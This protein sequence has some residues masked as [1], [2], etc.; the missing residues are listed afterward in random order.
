MKRT[1]KS[2]LSSFVVVGVWL[3]FGKPLPAQQAAPSLDEV[4]NQGLKAYESLAQREAAAEDSSF[5]SNVA[6]ALLTYALLRVGRREAVDDLFS[7]EAKK[8]EVVAFTEDALVE[9]TGEVPEIPSGMAPADELV[10]RQTIAMSLARRGDFKKAVEQ[11]AEFPKHA[12]MG[13]FAIHSYQF[14]AERQLERQDLAGAR[15]TVRK[16]WAYIRD[17][18]DNDSYR[19]AEWIIQLARTTSQAGEQKPAQKLCRIAGK[20]L[21]QLRQTQGHEPQPL[22]DAVRELAIAHAMSGNADRA[23]A[24]LADCE[25]QAESIE[26]GRDKAEHMFD[27]QVAHARVAQFSGHS[28]AALAAY[29]RALKWA[30]QINYDSAAAMA[31]LVDD[32]GFIS[33]LLSLG[34]GASF[35]T[36]ALG[37]LEAGDKQAALKT[38]EQMPL[39]LQKPAT[40][41]E[42]AK[43]L[44]AKSATAEA[45]EL[46]A[47]CAALDHPGSPAEDHVIITAFVAHIYHAI[48]DED[49]ARQTLDSLLASPRVKEPLNA[50][51]M[52]TGELS[53]F[54]MFQ[55]A[56]AVIQ[57]IE[58]PADRA[59]PLAKLAE[60]MAKSP[61]R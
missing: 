9:A 61:H 7:D 43:A 18:E 14:V 21:S 17:L 37:Q 34:E 1:A 6:R 56:Y 33:A 4:L 46:A 42:M 23:R 53:S 20:L 27:I 44:H 41:L 10:R 54:G 31:D 49:S 5:E 12:N 60:A 2:V 38:W 15:Q 57:T 11:I 13:H 51:K 47:R 24:L 3:S 16:T 45:R 50:K 26:D 48:G 55:E 35:R 59:L 8:R 28:D 19:K 39:C 58:S 40:L 52:L 25:R 32:S 22:I 30:K 36:V 29:G